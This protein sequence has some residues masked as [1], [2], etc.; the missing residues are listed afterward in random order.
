VDYEVNPFSEDWSLERWGLYYWANT[1]GMCAFLQN[2]S[3]TLLHQAQDSGIPIKTPFEGLVRSWKE[4][5][6]RQEE[7]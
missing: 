1:A 6:G 5:F 3:A 2:G 7:S 4:E